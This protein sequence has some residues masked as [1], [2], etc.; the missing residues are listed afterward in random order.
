[1]PEEELQVRRGAIAGPSAAEAHAACAAQGRLVV[2]LCNLQA[3]NMRGVKSFGMLLAA[4][5][6]AHENV[7]LVRPQLARASACA[8]RNSRCPRRAAVAAGGG[9]GGRAC[10]LR[11]CAANRPRLGEQVRRSGASACQVISSDACCVCCASPR[12]QKKKIWEAVQ[13]DLR[14]S[15]AGA[16]SWK[17]LP[18][19][20]SAG[21]VSVKRILN[22]HIS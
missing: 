15:A 19:L 9:E 13:P 8:H 12:V 21:P 3:R 1:V 18:M 14:T 11:R 16:A 7:E 10:A 2:V 6:E 20:T 17:D 22:G 5:D 4:S